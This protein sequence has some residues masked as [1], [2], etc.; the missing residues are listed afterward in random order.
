MKGLLVD[1]NV[2]LDVFLDD[3]E[4]ADWSESVLAQY[5]VDTIL[6]INSIVYTEV[7]VGFKKIED[8]ESALMKGGFQMLDIPKEALFLA[9]KVFLNYRK[10]R[11]SKTS[12]LPDFYIGAHAAVLDLDLLTRDVGRYKTYFPTVS[13]IS[14]E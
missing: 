6:Y 10:S 14:P 13:T 3:A 9:G 11:G 4:W 8:L 2:I 7:S 12:P 1:S 5:S